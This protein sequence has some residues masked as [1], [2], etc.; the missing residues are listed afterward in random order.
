MRRYHLSLA[1]MVR[2][3]LVIVPGEAR[4]AGLV[5]HPG[6]G[7]IAVARERRVLVVRR[8]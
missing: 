1:L 2:V 8:V 3:W 7:V 4:A 6:E 5:V